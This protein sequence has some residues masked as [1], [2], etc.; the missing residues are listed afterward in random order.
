[1]VFPCLDPSLDHAI[2][3]PKAQPVEVPGGADNLRALRAGGAGLSV[4]LRKELAGEPAGP[5][6]GW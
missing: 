3:G 4:E 5:V 2:H 6:G 1:M